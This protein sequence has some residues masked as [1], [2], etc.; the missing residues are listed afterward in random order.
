MRKN[1]KREQASQLSQSLK[2]TVG[3]PIEF[4][5]LRSLEEADKLFGL[6]HRTDLDFTILLG[7]VQAL[8]RLEAE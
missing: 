1:L 7:E 8:T 6:K 3:F 2:F 5:R 4:E